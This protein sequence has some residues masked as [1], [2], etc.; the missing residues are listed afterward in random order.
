MLLE[1]A[2]IME[3]SLA[4]AGMLGALAGVIKASNCKKVSI[5]KI[6]ECEKAQ[7]STTETELTEK[8]DNSFSN[9]IELKNEI[10]GKV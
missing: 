4:I 6:I 9:K 3:W 7:I 10:E 8:D 2:T 1:T 5:C